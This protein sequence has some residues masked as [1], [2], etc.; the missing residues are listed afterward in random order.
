MRGNHS[1]LE[2]VVADL[3]AHEPLTTLLPEAD[4]IYQSHPSDDRDYMASV[5]VTSIFEGS[6]RHRGALTRNYRIQVTVKTTREWRE[7]YD[8][9]D[10]QPAGITQQ[11]KILSRV[12][13]VLDTTGTSD[14]PEIPTGGEGGPNPETMDGD[15]LA[16]ISDWTLQGTYS[17]D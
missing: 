3:R 13:D 11:G 10:D 15:R 6:Q 4:A 14:G 9:R 12:A 2:S 1:V 5:T 7:A 17:T 16:M 8:S